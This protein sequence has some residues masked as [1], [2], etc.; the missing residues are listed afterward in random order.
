VRPHPRH[1][2]GDATMVSLYREPPIERRRFRIVRPSGPSLL[3]PRGV[4]IRVFVGDLEELKTDPLADL[5]WARWDC[6]KSPAVAEF[7]IRIWMRKGINNP[8]CD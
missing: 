6:A 3:G 2:R 7:K 8:F 5:R 4:S 1:E